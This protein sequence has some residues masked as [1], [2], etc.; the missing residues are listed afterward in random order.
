MWE[1]TC[2]LVV[3]VTESNGKHRDDLPTSD[4]AKWERGDVKV[5]LK[6]VLGKTDLPVVYLLFQKAPSLAAMHDRHR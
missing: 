2:L 3:T 5:L 6:K 4:G 1:V